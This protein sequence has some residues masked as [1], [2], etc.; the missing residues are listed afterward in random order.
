MQYPE[1]P[2]RGSTSPNTTQAVTERDRGNDV[3][4]I[5]YNR[6]LLAPHFIVRDVK[7]GNPEHAQAA[8]FL[9]NATTLAIAPYNF[10]IA[11]TETGLLAFSVLHFDIKPQSVLKVKTIDNEGSRSEE[12][13]QLHQ[14]EPPSSSRPRSESS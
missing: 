3:T 1:R 2:L 13:P 12:Q 9:M 14:E 10:N 4:V 6:R 7:S 8:M 5:R 11:N